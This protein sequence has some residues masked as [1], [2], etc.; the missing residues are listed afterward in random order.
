MHLLSYWLVLWWA[1]P[2]NEQLSVLQCAP[3]P[4]DQLSKGDPYWLF[5]QQSVEWWSSGGERGK[6]W[7]LPFSL[8]LFC[9]LDLCHSVSLGSPGNR[10]EPAELQSPRH[11]CSLARSRS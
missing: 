9:S 6:S 7:I 4:S 3:L 8:G 1:P 2:H 10:L 11:G 5:S